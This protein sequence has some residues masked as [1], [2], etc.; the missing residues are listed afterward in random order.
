MRSWLGSGAALFA[1][2]LVT[3]GAAGLASAQP[4]GAQG[5]TVEL[6]ASGLTNPQDIAV[7]ADGTIYISDSGAGRVVRG[8]RTGPFTE[9]ASGFSVGS[10]FGVNLSSAGLHVRGNDVFVGEAGR[11]LGQDQVYQYDSNGTLIKAFPGISRGGNWSGL[12]TNPAG[13]LLAASAN[14]DGIFRATRNTD[15][16]YSDLSLFIDTQDAPA[17]R[18]SPVG[19]VQSGNILY[20]AYY[21]NF[22]SGGYIST[23]DATTGVLLNPDFAFGLSGPTSID[24]LPDGR[25]VVSDYGFDTNDGQVVIIDPISGLPDGVVS[26]L[27]FAAGIAVANDGSIY[28]SEMVDINSPTGNVWRVVPSSGTLA[29]FGAGGVL[30][31]R[32]RRGR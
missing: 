9:F 10:F 22:G 13:D 20:V 27:R 11:P 24:I 30:A 17:P 3:L 7:A 32:R 21:G 4:V 14:G 5:F 16:T 18:I 8:P 2:G 28:V 6:I 29:L 26:G 12:Y 23:Y 19:M 31:M 25:L 15:G 1:G